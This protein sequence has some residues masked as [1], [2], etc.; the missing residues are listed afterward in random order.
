MIRVRSTRLAR[1][2]SC[3]M[4]VAASG[5]AA[6][7]TLEADLILR[8]GA[9]Y[10]PN[11]W[12]EA[13]AVENGVIIAVGS[14]AEVDAHRVASTEVI[15]LDGAAV[16]PGFHDMHVHPLGAGLAQR[17]CTF[18]Q[19][20]PPAVIVAAVRACA[21]RRAEGEWIAGGQWDAASFGDEPV[22]RRLLD[23]AAPNNPVTLTDISGHSAWANTAALEL[24]GITATTPNPPGGIIERDGAGRATGVLRE[25]AAGLVRRLIPPV[26]TEE[27]LAALRWALDRMLEHGITSFTDAVASEP[28]L[29]AYATLADEGLLK[30]RVRACMMWGG[31]APASGGLPSHIAHR[32]FYARDRFSPTCVKLL[33]DGVPTDGHTAAMVE[34]YADAAG[35]ASG[36]RGLLMMPQDALDAVVTRLDALGLTVKMHAAGDAA[37]RAGLDAIEAARRANGFG[38]QLHE[39]AH[40]SFVQPSDIERAPA[41]GATFEMSPYIWYPN[42]IIPDISKAVGAERM[43]RWI[44]LADA[45]EAGALVVPGS[46][47]PVVPNVDPWIAIETLVTRQPPGGG[48][49]ALGE[50]QK[51]SLEQAVELFTVNAARQLG[52]RDRLG[53][54]ERGMLADLVVVDRNPFEIPINE[55]HETGVLMT[56][57]EG[58]LV[59]RK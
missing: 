37:V 53:T 14:T 38:G 26:T 24:A 36:D 28:S 32:N 34:P 49:E 23:E 44:P 40:N 52:E 22:D 7:P 41:L 55:V 51:I 56:F 13:I 43:L 25:S 11:G 8:G 2:L 33:L 12:A 27:S 58:E 45:I 29:Q 46:D 16:L 6:A 54:I 30:Q 42:P 4:A 48:G 15:D 9:V 47:W 39:L 35:P 31:A 21:E 17:E 20:S 10:T 50:S 57:I 5:A 1:A 3:A 18:P 59:Y 19:G